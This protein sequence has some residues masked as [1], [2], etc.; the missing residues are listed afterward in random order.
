VIKPCQSPVVLRAHCHM[1]D[2]THVMS[3][4]AGNVA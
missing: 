1:T 2:F 3:S 4:F